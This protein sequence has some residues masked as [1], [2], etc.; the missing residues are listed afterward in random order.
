MEA[1]AGLMPEGTEER[2][3]LLAA[4]SW[5]PFFGGDRRSKAK[6]SGPVAC[7]CPSELSDSAR[8]PGKQAD[9]QRQRQTGTQQTKTASEEQ[10]L[11]TLDNF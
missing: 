3:D 8:G 1:A 7:P 9:K 4:Q 10:R 2:G 5:L 11:L 6:A